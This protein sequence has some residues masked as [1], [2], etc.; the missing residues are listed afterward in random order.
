MCLQEELR[1]LK[2]ETMALE[3][4][5]ERLFTDGNHNLTRWNSIQ[6]RI[7]EIEKELT[8]RNTVLSS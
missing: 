2:R 5:D 1:I 4:G 8:E 3:Y 7:R 6:V